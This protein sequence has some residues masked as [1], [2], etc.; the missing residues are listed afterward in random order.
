MTTHDARAYFG[1]GYARRVLLASPP[2]ALLLVGRHSPFHGLGVM[3]ADAS[4][5]VFNVW[6]A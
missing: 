1:H 2:R 4:R 6:A 3:L 5:L